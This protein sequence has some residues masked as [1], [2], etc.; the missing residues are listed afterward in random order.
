MEKNFGTFRKATFGGFNRKD[1]ISYVEKIKNETFEYRCQVE[2]TVRKLNEKISEL[3]GAL[4]GADNTLHVTAKSDKS[5][6]STDESYTDIKDA[7]EHLKNVADELCSSLGE[8]IEKLSQK[9]LCEDNSEKETL[10]EESA[11]ASD[12]VESILSALSFIADKNETKK[13]AEAT[14]EKPADIDTILSSLSF[15]Y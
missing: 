10:Y 1:V 13:S 8:F 4:A 2:D 15:L 12:G 5:F 14:E 3:E 7:T 11:E 6:Y 9:G